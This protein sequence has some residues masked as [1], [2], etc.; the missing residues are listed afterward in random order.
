MNSRPTLL[1]LVALFCLTLFPLFG[2][3][4]EGGDG[5]I[6]PGPDLVERSVG[7]P[8]ATLQPEAVFT[9]G[10]TVVNEGSAATEAD[11][12]TRY[13]LSANTDKDSADRLLLGTRLVP[14]GLAAAANS[15]GTANLTVPA[16][17]RAG[18]YYL[19]VCADNLRKVAE[20]NEGNNC[21]A[22]ATTVVVSGSDLVITT[23]RNPPANLRADASFLG[24]DV[25]I[26]RGSVPTAV[27]A[28]IRYYFSTDTDRDSSDRP[29][30][31]HR[32]V[33]AGLATASTSVGTPRLTVPANMPVG[34]YYLIACVD[35]MQQISETNEDN[36]CTTSVTTTQVV[37]PPSI[38]SFSAVPDVLDLGGTA[39]LTPVFSGGTATVT[40][41]RVVTS[42]EEVQVTPAHT[43]TYTLRV[44]NALG[45]VATRTITVV[46]NTPS[47][48]VS[49]STSSLSVNGKQIFSAEVRGI[50]SSTVAWRVVEVGGG[51]ITSAGVYTAPATPGTYHVRAVSTVS[52]KVWA[53][54]PVIVNPAGT[55]RVTISPGGGS[56]VVGESQG[57]S[58]SV[59][60]S[61]NPRVTWSIVGTCG[62]TVT[63]TGAS[64][65]T[66][67]APG[68]PVTCR[69]RAT[70]VADPT[71]R[72]TATFSV[73]SG[74]SIQ[75]D[76]LA[77][78]LR[79]GAV[80]SFR[81]NI[82]GLID[83]RVRWA[84]AGG[85]TGGTLDHAQANPVH[86][87][88]P[89]VAGTY[90]LTVKSVAD[91]TLTATAT[92]VVTNAVAVDVTPATMELRT[93]DAGIFTAVVTGAVDSSVTWS[94]T[95][96]ATGGTI[97]HG[98]Y[99]PSEAASGQ[100]FHVVATSTED[101]SVSASALVSVLPSPT[102]AQFQSVGPMARPRVEHSTTRLGNGKVLVVGGYDGSIFQ[103][104]AEIY[105]PVAQTFS[106]TGDMSIG[107]HLHTATALDATHVL[108]TGGEAPGISVL[109][110]SEVWDANTD[111]FTAVGDMNVARIFH[112]AV[113]LQDGRVLIAGG[114][115]R[116]W[117]APLA[118]AE[119]YSPTT[120]TFTPLP[121]GMKTARSNFTATLLQD[122]KVFILG[123][124]NSDS[125]APVTAE[126]F[127]PADGSFRYTAGSPFVGRFRHTA[128]LLSD[129]RV[130]IV[131]G[132]I[133]PD[134]VEIYNPVT[135]RFSLVPATPRV[136]RLDHSACLL[137]DGRV[138]I[139]GGQQGAVTFF[140]T[141]EIF[142][143]S[144]STFEF[145]ALLNRPRRNTEALLLETGQ[146]LIVGGED[147]VA[148]TS[149]AETFP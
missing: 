1:N 86:Y 45:D 88:A 5:L 117:V 110:T 65:A 119:I 138:L 148:L 142:D 146:V 16:N 79:A 124:E 126:I 55:V 143:P 2:H 38:T 32:F 17:T 100:T 21:T 8:P 30:I 50:V 69:V 36:N 101:P 98:R 57:L 132:V 111:T 129:G 94:L 67:T 12:L 41:P 83:T 128:T 137:S 96:G 89:G 19:I 43:T 34:A 87:T 99:L 114:N 81:A 25:V 71:A 145:H 105:D 11:A 102:V 118:S 39:T 60:G 97:D 78:V 125:S 73:V 13:Y 48:T 93:V 121:S 115:D 58:A 68:T 62:G 56:L 136:G 134:S 26:N 147:G 22:S 61:S 59:T 141:A 109:A 27:D 35:K 31:G 108:V 72:S 103:P 122:G 104:S 24:R 10:D 52:S 46:V 76:P 66:F 95:E 90:H 63:A 91:P 64:T 106:S 37:S 7:N 6:S 3:T 116:F 133:S 74:K 140:G 120:H 54:V 14:A 139:I 84:V 113:R 23:L 9:T 53:E 80:Q 40:G 144:L 51:R 130:L 127:D 4:T 112:R 107:R 82:A 44:V 131:G 149:S 92:I 20:T 18:R 47:V 49:P 75:I 70:S 29:L 135:D 85:L 123:G 33:P 28:L 77:P 15:A 42:G